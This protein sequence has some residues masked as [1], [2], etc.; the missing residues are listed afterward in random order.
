LTPLRDPRALADALI[1]MLNDRRDALMM[2][3]R[4]PQ[5]IRGSFSLDNVVS[6]HAELYERLL[7]RGRLTQGGLQQAAE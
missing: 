3:A 7:K 6:L 5:L 4:A 1:E 2:A